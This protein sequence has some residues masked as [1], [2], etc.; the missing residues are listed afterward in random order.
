M[1]LLFPSPSFL[2]SEHHEV[3]NGLPYISHQCALA[4]SQ[5]HKANYSEMEAHKGIN[6]QKPFNH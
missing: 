1:F 6:Q 4:L 3:S 2:S 5:A